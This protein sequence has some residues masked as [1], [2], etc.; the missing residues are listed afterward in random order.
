MIEGKYEDGEVDRDSE[1]NEM[2][3]LVH[4][5][6]SDEELYQL[7][8]SDLSWKRKTITWLMVEETEL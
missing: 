6:A 7:L 2:H 5:Q 1:I 4:L 3:G 8:H